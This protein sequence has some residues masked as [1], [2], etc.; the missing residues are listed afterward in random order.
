MTTTTTAMERNV[1]FEEQNIDRL[2]SR[3]DDALQKFAAIDSITMVSLQ[4]QIEALREDPVISLTKCSSGENN[5]TIHNY[6]SSSFPVV[7]TGSRDVN[8]DAGNS[9]SD[10]ETKKSPIHDDDDDDEKT[11][12]IIDGEVNVVDVKAAI[13]LVD[14]YGDRGDYQGEVLLSRKSLNH[15]SSDDVSRKEDDIPHGLGTM[16]YADGRTYKGRWKNGQ[17]HGNGKATYPNGDTYEG[18]YHQ[19]Q[20]HTGSSQGI[21]KWSDGRIFQGDFKNDQRNGHGVYKWPDGSN[22][23]GGF[24]EG[25]RHGEG[26]YTLHDENVY[27]G[28]WRRGSRQG[29]GEYHW[30]DGRIYK[31]EWVDGKAHGYGV[32]IRAD[33]SVRH[34]GQ[35]GNDQPILLTKGDNTDNTNNNDSNSNSESNSNSNSKQRALLPTTRE[36]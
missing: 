23:E 31:G 26:T 24:Q 4:K 16:N 1:V 22:Y 20:R 34:D 12:D 11:E 32:E 15:R 35:W 2:K 13:P 14:P 33:G 30:V 17:W 9:D 27:T 7:E 29:T 5:N 10:V 19:D 8:V 21:Y 36:L 6:T 25:Q 3:V 18:M 28:E